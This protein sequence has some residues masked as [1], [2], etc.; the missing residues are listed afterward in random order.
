MK[1]RTPKS[2][3]D[4]MWLIAKVLFMAAPSL[5]IRP[6]APASPLTL[7]ISGHAGNHSASSLLQPLLSLSEEHRRKFLFSCAK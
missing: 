6:V 5:A 1:Y 3:S 2:Y 4:K 7:I